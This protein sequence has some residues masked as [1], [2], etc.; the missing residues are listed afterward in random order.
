MLVGGKVTESSPAPWVGDVKGHTWCFGGCETCQEDP[1]ILLCSGLGMYHCP[2]CGMMVV[3]GMKHP[4][5]SQLDTQ[6]AEAMKNDDG[7]IPEFDE[8]E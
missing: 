8:D 6:L 2:G 7:S 5:C 3:A 4:T 1:E